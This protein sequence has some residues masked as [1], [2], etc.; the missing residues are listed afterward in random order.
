MSTQGRL[1]INDLQSKITQL[2]EQLKNITVF[3]IKEC[4]NCIFNVEESC[5]LSEDEVVS[6]GVSLLCPLREK[7]MLFK[8]DSKA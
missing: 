4:Y 8:L 5:L 2:E 3:T 7:S 1:I 6:S